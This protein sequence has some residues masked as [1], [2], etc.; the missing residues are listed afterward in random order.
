VVTTATIGHVVRSR[1]FTLIEIQYLPAV[2]LVANQSAIVNVSNTSTE[3]VEFIVDIYSASGTLLASKTVTLPA[4]QTFALLY[5]N[6]LSGNRTIRAVVSLGTASAA[7]S[8]LVTFD[9]TSG[10]IIAIVPAVKIT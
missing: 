4:G 8:D 5:L 1:A 9:K 3:S 2:Q 10:E 6:R 7:V